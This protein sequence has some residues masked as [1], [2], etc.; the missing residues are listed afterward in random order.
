MITK[1]QAT[2]AF[3]L[4]SANYMHEMWCIGMFVCYN[5]SVG[6][7]ILL[8]VLEDS[9]VDYYTIIPNS[10]GNVPILFEKVTVSA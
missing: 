5:E 10:V 2:K 8:H 9:T 1:K 4:L 7:Y 3:N 6:Y